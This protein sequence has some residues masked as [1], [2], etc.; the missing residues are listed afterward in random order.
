MRV[1]TLC[2][3][4]FAC[5]TAPPALRVSAALSTMAAVPAQRRLRDSVLLGQRGE[6]LARIAGSLDLGP[7][8]MPADTA[9]V[10]DLD[11]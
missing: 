10:L 7:P 6:R 11:E 8:L 9:V 5:R 1:T 4:P 2:L 3:L